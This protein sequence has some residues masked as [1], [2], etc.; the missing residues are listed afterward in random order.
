MT[1]IIIS[2]ISTLIALLS[3]YVVFVNYRKDKPKL[4]IYYDIMCS[5]D[6]TKEWI[7]VFFINTGRRATC[8]KSIG[9]FDWTLGTYLS[10]GGDKYEKIL[11]EGEFGSY[12]IEISSND[13][14]RIKTIFV[15]DYFNN[16]WEVSKKRMKFLHDSAHNYKR[17]YSKI[18]NSFKKRRESS[19]N[20]YLR[21]LE[22]N[23]YSNST[24]EIKRFKETGEIKD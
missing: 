11:K 19:L 18:G 20:E 6:R 17:D 8:L 5:T 21:F 24:K 16:T 23:N 9:Y 10:K 2:I 15:S 13:Q 22:K 12:D 4:E 7:R 14:W 1:S 3:F